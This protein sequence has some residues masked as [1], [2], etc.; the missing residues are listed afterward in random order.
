M[1]RVFQL[2]KVIDFRQVNQTNVPLFPYLDLSVIKFLQEFR[3]LHVGSYDTASSRLGLTNSI[4][5]SPDV[6]IY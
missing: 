1:A 6:L 5:E 3:R 2:I 4:M